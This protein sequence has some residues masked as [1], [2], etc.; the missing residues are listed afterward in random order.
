MMKPY[1]QQGSNHS[2]YRPAYYRIPSTGH[3]HKETSGEMMNSIVVPSMSNT[4]S[5]YMYNRQL[6]Y[7]PIINHVPIHHTLE[8][9]IITYDTTIEHQQKDLVKDVFFSPPMNDREMS[10]SS[11]SST[12][13]DDDR[14]FSP[15]ELLALEEESGLFNFGLEPLDKK[16]GLNQKTFKAN[17]ELSTPPAVDYVVSRKRRW[18]DT[19]LEHNKKQK[20]Q[21]L[22]AENEVG[23]DGYFEESDDED[24]ISQHSTLTLFEQDELSSVGSW[25]E[26]KLY[27][28]KH[29]KQPKKIEISIQSDPYQHIPKTKPRPTAQPTIYQ[30]LTK[31]N[32]DWCR[33]CGTTE[34]VN[35]RPGPWG[36]RTLCNKHGCDYKGYGFACKLPRLDL[37]QFTKESIDQRH[38]PVLQ[39]YCSSCQRNE[40]WQGNVLVRCEGCPKAYHQKCC[41]QELT[42]AFVLSTEPWFCTESCSENSRRKRI[43]V[44]LP[45]KRLPLMSAP[46]KSTPLENKRFSIS[47]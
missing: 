7:Q 32:I 4:L 42:D 28:K 46:S 25:E 27:T 11:V 19:I 14:S 36:K 3:L 2:I 23:L 44:D 17:Q 9:A 6:N 10:P 8:N 43:I 24:S 39:L 38:R 41:P 16:P 37:T 18:S 5:Y 35:W 29:Q 40:S 21:D 22:T 30:K 20:L 47:K 33:Y 12:Q 15:I 13:S 1:S 26:D 31:A 45:R 34:G